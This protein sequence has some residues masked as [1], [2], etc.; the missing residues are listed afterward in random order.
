MFETRAKRQIVHDSGNLFSVLFS[1][2]TF[3][4]IGYFLDICPEDFPEIREHLPGLPGNYIPT[5]PAH[6][7]HFTGSFLCTI[8]P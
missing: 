4:E 6:C 2:K 7:Q 8:F 3:P 1:R 5:L